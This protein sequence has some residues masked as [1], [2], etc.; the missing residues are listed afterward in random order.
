HGMDHGELIG[1][2]GWYAKGQVYAYLSGGVSLYV[3]I[4][5]HSGEIDIFTVG[6]AAMLQGGFPDPTWVK[7]TVAGSYSVLHGA[8]S[9]SFTFPFEL[10]EPCASPSDDILSGLEPIGDITPRHNDGITYNQATGVDCGVD[11]SVVFNMKTNTPFDVYQIESNGNRLLRTFRL[12]VETFELKEGVNMLTASTVT[13]MTKDQIT[14][15]PAAFLKPYTIHSVR[16]KLKMEELKNGVWAAALKNN[17]PVFWDKTN[18]FKTGAGPDK[19]IPN[20]VDYTYP[21]TDQRY[22]LQDECRK[23]MIQLKSDMSGTPVFAPPTAAN[24]VRNYKILFVPR[25]SAAIT[26]VNATVTHSGK[27][28][29]HFDVPELMSGNIYGIQFIWRDSLVAPTSPFDVISASMAPMATMMSAEINTSTTSLHQ[30]LANLNIRTLGGYNVKAN[31]KLLYNYNFRTSMHRSLAAKAAGFMHSGTQHSANPAGSSYEILSPYFSGEPFDV[32]DVNGY[33]YSTGSI[34]PLVKLSEARTDQW[35]SAWNQPVIYTYYQNILNSSQ[36]L[37]SL[38]LIRGQM[39]LYGPFGMNWVF[40]GPDTI[41]IPPVNTVHFHPYNYAAGPLSQQEGAPSGGIGMDV[42]LFSTEISD[43]GAPSASLYLNVT[44]G[45]YVKQDFDRMQTITSSIIDGYGSPY[46]VESFIPEPVRSNMKTF[47][48]SSYRNM[49]QG[50]YK[51][52]FHFQDPPGNCIPT[53]LYFSTGP[54][55]PPVSGTATYPHPTGTLPPNILQSQ[56]FDLGT[57]DK[58]FS[59]K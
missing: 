1:I 11:P 50:N 34:A 37:T 38:G 57:T 12:I 40:Y 25:I 32:F 5:V 47:L 54:T 31:E 24:T 44:T 36:N 16:I 8:V 4:F 43:G 58:F 39:V 14:L 30:G 45:T 10:G 53:I 29:V 9:G 42:G 2:N 35:T 49:Y 15:I 27:S 19:I 20:Y 17:A 26:E 7:G 28:M 22:F 13:P 46:A 6:A 18:V 48:S 41:G 56:A 23:G 51:V 59:T 3:D 52:N 33:D 21:F 55:F